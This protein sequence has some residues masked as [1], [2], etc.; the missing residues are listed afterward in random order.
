M[1]HH[2][3]RSFTSGSLRSLRLRFCVE[4]SLVRGAIN[5]FCKNDIQE[6]TRIGYAPGA[7]KRPTTMENGFMRG[8]LTRGFCGVYFAP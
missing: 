1:V 6:T 5:V 4:K 7:V 3:R 2:G 8:S